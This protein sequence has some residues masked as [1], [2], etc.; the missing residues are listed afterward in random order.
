[1]HF[2]SLD[3]N[4][5]FLVLFECLVV[6]KFLFFIYKFTLLKIRLSSSGIAQKSVVIC[7]EL[8]VLNYVSINY[9]YG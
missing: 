5:K 6:Q 7:A 3:F 9:T 4:I 8:V 2:R 1:M